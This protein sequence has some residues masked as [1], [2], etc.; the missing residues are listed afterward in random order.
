MTWFS[1][2]SSTEAREH[3][4]ASDVG[5]SAIHDQRAEMIRQS[6]VS[7]PEHREC[8]LNEPLSGRCNDNGLSG[9]DVGAAALSGPPSGGRR[10]YPRV[11]NARRTAEPDPFEV[12]PTDKAVR[13]TPFHG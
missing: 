11:R 1:G 8:P 9:D 5:P 10:G 4:V 6:S 3:G 2:A 13:T 12:D 7:L